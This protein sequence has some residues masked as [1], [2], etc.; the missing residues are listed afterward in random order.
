MPACSIQLSLRK[1]MSQMGILFL[2]FA[3]AVS[4]CSLFTVRP[5]Q[6][7]SDTA[8]AIQAAREVQAD[9]I[10]PDSY[11]KAS[12]WFF[13]AKRE[14]KF[15]NFSVAK[16]YARRARKLAEQAEFDSIQTGATRSDQGGADPFAMK[17]PAESAQAE[18]EIPQ[19]QQHQPYPYPTPTG[20]P[21]D[22]YEERKAAE[23][24]KAQA[25]LEAKNRPS[26]TP[27][28]EPTAVIINNPPRNRP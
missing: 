7:M 28:P 1:R 19:Q 23:D 14:Y 22:V 4:S 11:R 21:G 18:A 3:W 15:K 24:A 6:E 9:T 20:T 12:E 27:S 25:E 17:I 26:P 10:A 16:E 2:F 13:K 8:S 5:V